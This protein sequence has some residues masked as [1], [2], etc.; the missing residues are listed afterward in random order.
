MT[1]TCRYWQKVFPESFALVV[2][3]MALC[4]TYSFSMDRVL[5][6]T[7]VSSFMP[8]RLGPNALRMPKEERC[9][10]KRKLHSFANCELFA[11]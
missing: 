9:G 2:F 11:K 10:E 4:L 1:E 3:Q 8:I 6:N 7:D 5:V